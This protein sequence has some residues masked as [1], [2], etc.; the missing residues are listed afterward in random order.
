MSSSSSDMFLSGVETVLE[1]NAE[2]GETILETL[3]END[4]D[5]GISTEEISQ[6]VSEFYQPD[7]FE[8]LV[9]RKLGKMEDEGLLENQDGY[10]LTSKGEKVYRE[11]NDR[12]I[13]GINTYNDLAA[14]IQNLDAGKAV[15]EDLRNC[16]SRS[17][18]DLENTASEHFERYSRVMAGRKVNKMEDA[19]LVTELNGNYYSTIHGAKMYEK[20]FE[21]SLDDIEAN[22]HL[23]GS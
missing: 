23:T 14:I 4:G 20:I 19:G 1:D 13:D 10:R 11:M 15:M 22:G 2:A 16:Q 21:Q 7:N 17:R 18:E 5:T 3:E 6:Q 12:I 9:H 8:V